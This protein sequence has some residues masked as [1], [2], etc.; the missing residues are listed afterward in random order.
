MAAMP[1]RFWFRLAADCLRQGGVVAYPTEAVYGLGSDPFDA[2]AVYRLL[3]LKNRSVAKGLILI[4][5]H[6]EQIESLISV[7]NQEVAERLGKSWPGPVTYVIRAAPGVPAWLRG[8][9]DTLAVR[10][11]AHPVARE[12]CRIFGGAIVSTSAN[13]SHFPP[14]KTAVKLRK[15]F[16]IEEVVLL[17]GDLGDCRQPTPIYDALTGGQ[18]RA[19]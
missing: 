11:T 18:L 3:A 12:L 1:S 7:P 16:G 14:A 4:A 2:E 19:G 5:S 15:Y 13:R 8:G 6:Y 10:V 9:R 17:P